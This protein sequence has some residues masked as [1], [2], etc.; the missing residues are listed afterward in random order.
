MTATYHAAIDL[1]ASGGRVA[2]GTVKDGKL[3][4]EILH[5][6]NHAPLTVRGGLQWDILGIWSEVLTGLKLAAARAIALGGRVSS[7]GADS[8]GVDF[9][10][11]DEYGAVI[12]GVRAYR[13]PRTDA[14]FENAFEI[15]PRRDVFEITGLQ[16]M[17][18][19][20]LYQLLAVQ[21][22]TPT[23]L[24]RARTLL[25]VP[26]L[27][28]FWLSGRAVSER[29]DASTTQ[30]Y[31]PRHRDWAR[32]LLEAFGLRTHFLPELID[33]GIVIGPVLPDIALETGLED[34][35]VVAPG[36]HDTAA[37][38]AATPLEH[39]DAA[40]IS[41]GTWS[42]VGLEVNAPVITPASLEAN[43]TNEA[44]VNNTTRLLKN[45]MGLWILQEC[46]H[47]WN[48]PEWSE[49]YAAAEA[50]SPLVTFVDPN[51]ARFLHTGHD[52]PERVQAYCRDTNQP[53]P[54]SHG[55]I[56]RC[57]LESLALKYRSVLEM[58]E[59][60]TEKHVPLIHIVGGGS[61]VALLNQMTADATGLEV[62]AGPT[63]ATLTGNILMQAEAMGVLQHDR[64]EIVRRSFEL[65]R[66]TP[67]DSSAWDD[68][69][70]RFSSLTNSSAF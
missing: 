54:E 46:R 64:R 60:V 44:G 3:E 2:I 55:Q 49:L 53:I 58:L 52:M 26:D 41:S 17:S 37:A 27:I 47:A 39:P 23:H 32:G 34:V 65:Q 56:A 6:W 9:A 63:D 8:W 38:V 21:R 45:V 50:S 29:T 61:Q 70:E 4:V 24:E 10:L 19:N 7:V 69:F 51:D 12:D 31:D 5:R 40:Y 42:L 28:H 13:D 16:F 59:R 14:I 11:L 22:D 66:F 43:L 57:I 20:S 62:V 30:F 18:I 48:D 1:G 68:A 35:L 15:V 36:T 67:K 25:M 33:P